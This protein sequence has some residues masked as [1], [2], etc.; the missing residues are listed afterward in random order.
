MTVKR[1]LLAL[2][3]RLGWRNT[4]VFKI[5]EICYM[6]VRRVQERESRGREGWDLEHR[7]REAG[8]EIR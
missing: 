4:R 1:E 6:L 3:S 5:G 2:Q 8:F 7:C